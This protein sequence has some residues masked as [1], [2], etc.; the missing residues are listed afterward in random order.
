MMTLPTKQA[1]YGEVPAHFKRLVAD[2]LQEK[3]AP[4]RGKRRALI[5]IAA[6][7]TLVLAA[8]ALAVSLGWTANYTTMQ[9]ARKL[10][11]AEYNLT[12]ELLSV[13]YESLAKNQQGTVM[14]YQPRYTLYNKRLGVY[15]VEGFDAGSP[16]VTWNHDGKI[17]PEELETA[18]LDSPYWGAKQLAEAMRLEKAHATASREAY[19]ELAEGEALT[20]ADKAALDA[21]YVAAKYPGAHNVLPGADDLSVA[22]A[23]A[24]GKEA[25]ATKY[26]MDDDTLAAYT[27]T[28]AEL[29]REV[30]AT[31][32]QYY[33]QLTR[34]GVQDDRIDLV[35]DT[36]SAQV[37]A[38]VWQ[39][40]QGQLKLPE[41]PLDAYEEVVWE[42]IYSGAFVALSHADRAEVGQRISEAGFGA[43]L[44]NYHYVAPTE[45]TLTE[46]EAKAA[47]HETLVAE[48]GLDETMRALFTET[49]SLVEVDGKTLWV[50]DMVP[51]S[52]ETLHHV[53]I[54]R[55][56]EYRI[57]LNANT[58]DAIQVSWWFNQDRGFAPELT[59]TTWGDA[60]GWNAEILPWAMEFM[61]EVDAFI[62]AHASDYEWSLETRAAYDQM[63]RDV[64]FDS[65]AYNN[66]IPK[67][68]DLTEQ[69][70]ITLA[71]AAVEEAYDISATDL[72]AYGVY[73]TYAIKTQTSPQA[74]WIITFSNAGELYTASIAAE[75]GE[76]VGTRYA[77]ATGNG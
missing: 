9:T 61:A 30:D 75:T 7:M 58:G 36:P 49:Y 41:G 10:L 40:T 52:Q 16:K 60:P 8:T 5:L 32:A 73:I 68:G 47:V 26:G 4:V 53:F 34:E 35:V 22:D 37:I 62:Q 24:L 42:Y 2:T 21:I 20:M 17:T 23:T 69:E 74:A 44:Q 12:P 48:Y 43:Y 25:A 66:G 72:L 1:A 31:Q 55:L 70:A 14:H 19:A 50:M 56:G 33:I 39:N 63:F 77:M 57:I 76:V 29:T 59:E 45:E 46:A 67:E 11:N 15:T 38:C 27:A 71:L 64:G 3:A 6:L 13:F 65:D 18:G 51:A 28:Y 54:E